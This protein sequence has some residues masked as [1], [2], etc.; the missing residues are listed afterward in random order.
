[1]S[2]VGVKQI[3][4]VEEAVKGNFFLIIFKKRIDVNLRSMNMLT[5]C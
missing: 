5:S 1:M 2:I 3:D 4:Q